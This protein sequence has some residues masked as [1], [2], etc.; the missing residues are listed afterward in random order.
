[1]CGRYAVTLPLEAMRQLFQFDGQPNLAPN[2]D[3]RPTDLVPVIRHDGQN[4]RQIITLRWG[5]VPRFAKSID[6]KPLINARA[7]T[8]RDKPSFSEAMRSRRC[9]VP[10][11]FYYEWQT[12]PTSPKPVKK[13]F[14]IGRADGAMMAAAGLWEVWRTADGQILES[15]AILT[16]APDP[17][18]ADIH[19][20]MPIEIES[21]DIE[22]WLDPDTDHSRIDTMLIKPCPV[23]TARPQQ[24]TARP[25]PAPGQGDLFSP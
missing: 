17:E 15:M 4:R 10:M 11:D 25:K 8:A 5:F 24:S 3:V 14:A 9:L 22:A 18:I 7:E 1:M 16:R 13:P 23:R 12:D 20:R 6:P 21:G 19:D 2:L